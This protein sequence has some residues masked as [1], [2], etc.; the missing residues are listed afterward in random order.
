MVK[1]VKRENKE[2]N[3]KTVKIRAEHQCN[4]KTL[5]PAVWFFASSF[6]CS[7]P[8]AVLFNY[9]VSSQTSWQKVSKF[10]KAEPSWPGF[11]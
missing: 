2:K 3:G 5:F 1:E 8:A 4:L 6:V 9:F 11:A 7:Q 10:A